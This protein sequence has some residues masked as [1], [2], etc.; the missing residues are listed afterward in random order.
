MLFYSH[1]ICSHTVWWWKMFNEWSA[2][3]LESPSKKTYSLKVG[4]CVNKS[5]K[6]MIGK[7]TKCYTQSGEGKSGT[8]ISRQSR[9][10]GMKSHAHWGESDATM[11]FSRNF[12]MKGVGHIH[13]A[14]E[15]HH[16]PMVNRAFCFEGIRPHTRWGQ[17]EATRSSA[18]VLQWRN[19]ITYSLRVEPGCERFSRGFLVKWPDHILAKGGTRPWEDQHSLTVQGPYH[20]LPEG[21]ASVWKVQQWVW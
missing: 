12:A 6:K 14:A 13:A 16:E 5:A 18:G 9:S 7:C 11:R 19:Q 2:Y 17:N 10:N 4:K 15:Q 21:R 8:S 20:I 3:N 1:I